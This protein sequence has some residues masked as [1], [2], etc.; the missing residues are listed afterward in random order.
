M[1]YAS[2]GV[3]TVH[4]FYTDGHPNEFKWNSNY[5]IYYMAGMLY[6]SDGSP[7]RPLRQGLKAPDEGTRIFPGDAADIA[8]TA[9]F[10]WTVPAVPTWP[11][12]FGKCTRAPR[13][14]QRGKIIGTTTAVGTGLDGLITK[15][16]RSPSREDSVS[17][18]Q[19]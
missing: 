11:I 3:G 4:M 14:Q 18:R 2:N 12:R 1:K 9:I 17:A 6:K 16:L 19:D 13:R 5:H 8:W 10:G 7:I 15:C